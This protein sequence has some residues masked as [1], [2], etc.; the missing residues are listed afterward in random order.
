MTARPIERA[1]PPTQRQRRRERDTRGQIL[2]ASLRL[3]S[4]HGFARTTVRAIARDVGI[5]NAAIYYH[6]ASKQE[7]LE[8]LLDEKGIV[9]ALQELQQ[10]TTE[11]PP[12]VGL[13][14]IARQAMSLMQSNRDFLRLVLMEALG[15]E[16]TAVAVYRR[17]IELWEKGVSRFLKA[18]AQ[19]GLLRQVDVEMTARQIVIMV[20]TVFLG[21]L[22]GR[23]GSHQ[24]K[25]G[26]LSPV[27]DS[28]LAAALDNILHGILA[29]PASTSPDD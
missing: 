8:A 6:F 24:S 29:S 17:N 20:L 28:Y 15:G 3:F 16:A 2:D 22:V 12:R 4:Q 11:F 25:G 10:A 14:A 21:D 23:F 27:L 7:L 19:R 5:T 13:L 26:K 1:Q 9:P 18:Y